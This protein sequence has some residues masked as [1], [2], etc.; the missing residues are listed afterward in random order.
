MPL[1]PNIKPDYVY[2]GYWR[3]LTA[4]AY[5]QGL[6]TTTNIIALVFLGLLGIFGAFAGSK[7]W[8]IIRHFLQ[9]AVQ[10]SNSENK[11][12][13]LSRANAIRA[14]WAE[15]KDIRENLKIIWNKEHRTGQRLRMSFST[16]SGNYRPV[17]RPT[18]ATIEL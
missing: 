3:N 4:P 16:I 1:L 14:L 7:L 9:P 6:W 8:H 18:G 5:R 2:K 13:T 12:L 11:R 10:L 17:L 15:M